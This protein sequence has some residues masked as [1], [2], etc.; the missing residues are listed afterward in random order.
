MTPTSSRIAQ[1]LV[2]AGAPLAFATA[3]IASADEPGRT[4][5]LCSGDQT[6]GEDNCATPCPEGAPVNPHGTCPQRGTVYDAGTPADGLR[7][8]SRGADPEV[9]IGTN[10][11]EVAIGQSAE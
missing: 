6:P 8:D 2:A 4:V 10:P 1:T 3:P 7:P 11:D 5:P 9:P